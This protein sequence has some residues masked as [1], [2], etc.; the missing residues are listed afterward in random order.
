M[1]KKSTSYESPSLEAVT[2]ETDGTILVSSSSDSMGLNDL[3][4]EDIQWNN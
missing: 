3:T 4:Y 1:N 2:I